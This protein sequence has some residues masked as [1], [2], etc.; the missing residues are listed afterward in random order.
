MIVP[1]RDGPYLVRGPASLRDQDGRPIAVTRRTVAL[2]RCGKSRMRPF[3]DGTHRVVGFS[4]PS[5][6][7][8]PR[9]ESGAR[10]RDGRTVAS[11]HE[12][13]RDPNAIA[14]AQL[15]RAGAKVEALLAAPAAA[16]LYMKLR[17]VAP[18][19]DAA[20]LLLAQSA[21]RPEPLGQTPCVCLLKEAAAVLGSAR[22]GS[23]PEVGELVALLTSVVES[24]ERNG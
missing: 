8:H 18:L 24:L 2:C 4:A 10:D 5:H 22:G 12:I 1:Y 21:L 13:A 20:R 6:A 15:L 19:I 14:L 23:A 3:C 17:A 7:E 11:G 16:G 9:P